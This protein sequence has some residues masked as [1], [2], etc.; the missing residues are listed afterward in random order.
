VV[1]AGIV[2]INLKNIFIFDDRLSQLILREILL[3]PLPVPL[4]LCFLSTG[5]KARKNKTEKDNESNCEPF[6]VHLLSSMIIQD[7]N[8]YTTFGR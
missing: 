2:R 1:G 5:Q 6:P 7:T 3:S 4:L 8:A